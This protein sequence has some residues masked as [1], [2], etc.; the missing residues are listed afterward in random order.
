MRKCDI[1][2]QHVTS[3]RRCLEETFGDKHCGIYSGAYQ[4]RQQVYDAT[5]QS[6]RIELAVFLFDNKYKWSQFP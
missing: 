4:L 1:L 6:L 3:I 5:L 2:H